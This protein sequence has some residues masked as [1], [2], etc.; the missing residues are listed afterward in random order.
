MNTSEVLAA[1]SKAGAPEFAQAIENIR[2]V[3]GNGS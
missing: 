2:A 3:Q 1:L